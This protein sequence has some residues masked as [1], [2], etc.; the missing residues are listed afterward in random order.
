MDSA[1]MQQMVMALNSCGVDVA[2]FEFPYMHSRRLSGKRSPPNPMPRLLESF[3]EQ[4]REFQA[5]HTGPLLIGGKSMGGRVASMLADELGAAGLVCFGYP[6][7]PPGKPEK[8]RVDHLLTLVTPALIVQG[9]RDPFGKPPQV[10]GYALAP[11]VALHWL[12]TADHDFQPLKKS[13]NDQSVMIGQAASAVLEFL[14][15]RLR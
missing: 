15:N 13:G 12:D 5:G 14:E 7:H 11:T 1:F 4:W 3:R 10:S 9:T 8:T 2:R 6:F